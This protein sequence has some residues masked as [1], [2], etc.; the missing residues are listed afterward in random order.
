M[1]FNREADNRRAP[2]PSAPE[3]MEPVRGAMSLKNKASLPLGIVVERRAVDNP[4]IDHSWRATA[5]IAGAPA[6]SPFDDWTLLR[7][8]DGW[9]QYHAGTLALELFPKETDGYCL[10]LAQ[11]PPRIFIVLRK[12]EGRA[13]SHEVM[14]FHVTACPFE[15]QEYLDGDELVEVVPMPDLVAGFVRDFV[16]RHPRPPAF[17]KRKRKA[18]NEG[19]P[20]EPDNPVGRG[21]R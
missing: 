7:Q 6:L 5:V 16:E 3:A 1:T 9:A 13:A 11:T 19:T 18:W 4:W 8:G 17:E 15:A 10:N 12:G 21:R 2:R 20:S 14:P